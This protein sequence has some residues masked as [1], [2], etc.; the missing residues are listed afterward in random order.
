MS[1]PEKKSCGT[2]EH[3]QHKTDL[4]TGVC[5]LKPPVV[6]F[7][8]VT[9]NGPMLVTPW[10]EVTLDRDRCA[11][12][13]KRKGSVDFGGAPPGHIPLSLN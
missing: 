6:I 4:Q 7:A 3:C 2:C 9:R 5:R 13:E 11:E 1:E 12:W 8:G 10:P